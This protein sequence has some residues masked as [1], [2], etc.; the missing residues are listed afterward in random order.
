MNAPTPSANFREN[1]SRK[2]ARCRCSHHEILPG[3]N[4]CV[5]CRESDR[6]RYERDKQRIGEVKKA[7][8]QRRKAQFSP[9]EWRADRFR[10]AYKA[11]VTVEWLEATWAKQDGRCAITGRPLDWETLELDHIVPR[12]R[13]GTNDLS[14]LRLACH[15]G[16]TLKRNW[17][18]EEL[19]ALCREILATVAP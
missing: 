1:K 9:I 15:E 10:Y 12:S 3:R 13:G 19:V 4:T 14:N 16:N 18:D 11:P 7:Y 2:C 8:Y 5:S 17:L 6:A